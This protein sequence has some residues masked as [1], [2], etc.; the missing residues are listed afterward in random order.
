M[1]DVH[2]EVRMLLPWYAA[3]TLDARERRLVEDHLSACPSCARELRTWQRIRTTLRDLH[4]VPEAPPEVRDRVWILIHRSGCRP[5][6]LALLLAGLLGACAAA[7]AGWAVAFSPRP[8]PFVTL[9]RPTAQEGPVLQVVFE[10][11]AT[12]AQIRALLHTIPAT[13]RDGLRP[14]GLYLLQLRKGTDPAE[15]ARR[16]RQSPL[17]RFVEVAPR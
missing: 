8:A 15:A 14:S 7:A 17:V 1:R 5:R 10:P 2:H 11:W 6:R 13:L 3:G 9:A 4:E 16:L 12:E